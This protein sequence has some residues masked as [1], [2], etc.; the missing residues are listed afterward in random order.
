ML[1]VKHAIIR[2]TRTANNKQPTKKFQ[3]F[4]VIRNTWFSNTHN[5]FIRILLHILAQMLFML[6]VYFH[7]LCHAN[8]CKL[9][10]PI[11]I[12]TKASFWKLVS[13][14]LQ[15]QCIQM[16]ETNTCFNVH[17]REW[18]WGWASHLRIF[19]HARPTSAEIGT[20]IESWSE[21]KSRKEL[22]Y[23]RGEVESQ[24]KSQVESW[25]WTEGKDI[26]W[27]YGVIWWN[28]FI[29]LKLED[30]Q[31]TIRRCFCQNETEFHQSSNISALGGRFREPRNKT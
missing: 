17:C 12:E 28:S 19:I 30:T 26:E 15:I 21:I 20:K 22:K 10:M 31:D 16:T 24:V 23:A 29:F 8:I 7:S 4:S 2:K 14:P 6:L 3:S 18:A 13:T 11:K 1:C 9:E 27:C 25:K 5:I